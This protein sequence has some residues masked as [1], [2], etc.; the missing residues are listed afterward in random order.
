MRPLRSWIVA[1]VFFAQILFGLTVQVAVAPQASAA[2]CT[3]TFASDTLWQPVRNTTGGLLTDPLND[4]SGS[5]GN[6]NVDI[7]G[8]E[9]TSSA[10]AGSAIDWYSTG[11]SSCFQ[12]RMR[13]AQSPITGS[14]ID[15]Q[16]WIV[17]LGTSS[18]TNGWMV[19]DG[20][21]N[22]PNYV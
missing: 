16:L 22:N 15:N 8:T 20:N 4:V 19:V 17:G 3:S 10:A 11:S 21:N 12:F 2:T 9:A 18:T 13:V 7:Y 1:I 14:R 6:T 5:G